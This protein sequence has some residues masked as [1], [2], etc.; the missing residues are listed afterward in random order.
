MTHHVTR[1]TGNMEWYT[2]A[3]FVAAARFVMDGIDLDPATTFAV[4]EKFIHAKRILTLK[5]NAL[6]NDTLWAYP[7]AGVKTWLNPPYRQAIIDRFAQRLLAEIK[8]GAVG[9]AIWLS[10][11]ATETKWGQQILA[12][13][14]AICFPS[15]RIKF[16]SEEF[17]P[18]NNPTQGQ[19][20]VGLGPELNKD[21]FYIAFDTMGIV[22]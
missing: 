15:S 3:R 11:N 17:T 5:E 9:Q 6:D 10:N 16:L 22:R 18:V 7:R 21:R 8:T 13:S 12:N 2:P 14:S 4:N 1:T 20:L 19:M